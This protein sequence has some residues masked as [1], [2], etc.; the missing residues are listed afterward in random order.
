MRLGEL[1]SRARVPSVPPPMEV[2]PAKEP[3]AVRPQ[4]TPR[5]VVEAGAGFVVNSLRCLYVPEPQIHDAAQD[6]FVVALNRLG[7][8]EG[9]SSLRT[10]LYGICMRVALKY[11]RGA[12]RGRREAL[13]EELPEISVAAPQESELELADWQR[14]LDQAL[15]ELDEAQR[16]AFVLYEVE[17]LSMKEVAEA[18]NCPL[19]TA[20]YRHQAARAR[21]LKA[22]ERHEALEDP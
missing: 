19:Q 11:R 9:R 14:Q 8:F 6:V 16:M 13:V 4:F 12:M 10:W 1:F 21:V 20:Y 7:E 17:R 2:L 15:A 3:P 5:E 18:L 22:F